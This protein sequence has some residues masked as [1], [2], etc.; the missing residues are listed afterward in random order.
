M[1][2]ELKIVSIIIPCYN[3]ADSVVN[4]LESL[5]NQSVKNF[6]IIFIDDGSKDDSLNVAKK[7]LKESGLSYK[8][9]QQKN[10]GVSIAR[11][12]GIDVAKGKYLYF[13]DADDYVE[14]NFVELIS[15]YDKENFDICFFN[16]KIHYNDQIINLYNEH[17]HNMSK[18]D[19]IIKNILNQTFNY[20]IGSVV[21]K[22][23]II[24]NKNI[25]FIEDCKY[26]EDQEFVIRCLCNCKSVIVKN[27]YIFNYCMRQASAIHKFPKSRIDSIYSAIRVEKYIKKIYSNNETMIKLSEKY[28]ANQMLHNIR[29]FSKINRI[30]RIDNKIKKHLMDVIKSH[31]NYFRYLDYMEKI[32][33][34]KILM[35]F[36]LEKNL[37]LYFLLHEKL[38]N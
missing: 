28:V 4:T 25:N 26:G 33:V 22:R 35:K 16:Y 5:L 13:L 36:M 29:S 11:N 32:S 38:S 24:N 8:I 9:I 3:C 19:Y 30:N 1:N 18:V 31:S 37:G 6:E 14:D 34:K 15:Y 2:K 12:K 7:I 20:H 17:N 10:S 27:I 23:E 21:I